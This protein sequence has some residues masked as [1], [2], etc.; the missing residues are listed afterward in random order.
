[1]MSSCSSVLKL[2]LNSKFLRQLARIS[3]KFRNKENYG[4]EGEQRYDTRFYEHH[5][6]LQPEELD[7]SADSDERSLCHLDMYREL[8][9]VFSE[10]PK[11]FSSY[12]K[13][14]LRQLY[15]AYLLAPLYDMARSVS[16]RKAAVILAKGCLEEVQLHS[17][18]QD[19][20]LVTDITTALPIYLKM[21]SSEF[22]DES[23]VILRSMY[24]IVSA[25][26]KNG[27][28]KVTLERMSPL[29]EKSHAEISSLDSILF[30]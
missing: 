16:G 30:F 3:N 13:R 29:F 23:L 27:C 6:T 9:V 1:M 17:A 28:G 8:L 15:C 10:N 4:E 11:R 2:S 21:W 22:Q 14:M 25:N 19:E 12:R 5:G 20:T 24:L 26:D 18:E 7:P